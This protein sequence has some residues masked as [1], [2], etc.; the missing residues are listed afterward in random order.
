MTAVDPGSLD[1]RVA[2]L[3]KALARARPRARVAGLMADNGVDWVVADL[4]AERA[5][6]VLVPLPAFF[7]AAQLEHAVAAS[8]MDGVLGARLAWPARPA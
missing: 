6:V 7:T 4:A 1:A 3:A 8:G 2:R 5:G